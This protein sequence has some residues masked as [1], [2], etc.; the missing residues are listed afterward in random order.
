M[1]D[2]KIVFMGSLNISK[3]H[4]QEFMD[5]RAWRDTGIE[6]RFAE[7]NHETALLAKAFDRTWRLSALR[8]LFAQPTRLFRRRS[9]FRFRHRK[10]V[11]FRLNSR[12]WSRYLIFRDMIKRI[13]TAESRILITNAYFVPR[14]SMLVALRKAAKRGIF[15]GLILPEKTDVWFVRAASQTLYRKLIKSGV[16]LYEY[17]PRVLHAKTMVI[18]NWATVGSHNM[19]H[20]SML[21]DLEVETVI[22]SSE[23]I[24]Q[25]V[26]QWDNDA[27]ASK[28]YRLHDLTK[29]PWYQRGLSR[30]IY[31][32]RYWL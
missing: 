23:L 8:R 16:H 9:G 30:V 5:E 19:N 17:K 15:V 25:L 22:S 14:R 11:R 21:H 7:P 27:S 2:R 3:V 32:F 28:L 29:F 1:I 18:D 26:E 20:R 24:G 31:W 6:L 12:P 10:A 4:T 13:R